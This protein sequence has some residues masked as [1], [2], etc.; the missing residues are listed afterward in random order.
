MKKKYIISP[1]KYLSSYNEGEKIYIGISVDEKDTE[2]LKKIGFS[3]PLEEGEHILPS[4]LLG[5]CFMENSEG[6]VTIHKD[7]E[8]E[9]AY[10]Y[11]EW[12][13]TD[14]HGNWHTASAY[15]P[16][17][18]YPRSKSSP[19]NIEFAIYKD[20]NGDNLIVTSSPIE[21]KE[22]NAIYFKTAINMMLALFGRFETFNSNLNKPVSIIRRLPWELLRPGT[23]GMSAEKLYSLLDSVKNTRKK[24]YK[25]DIDFLM[26]FNPSMAAIGDKGFQGYVV[27][28]YSNK[29]IAIV[30]S[31]IPD[32]A[33]Y[34]FEDDWERFSK[35]TK[36]EVLN[37][38]L[39]KDRIFHNDSWKSRI[40]EYLD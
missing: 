10:S 12:D 33:T 6:I 17:K 15:I 36:T 22:S 34:V 13:F 1:F 27:F 37:A 14:W 40:K 21:K 29:N 19:L 26:S 9:T 7:M 16:Y 24:M 2:I 35:L 38:N 20:R 18:R 31:I 23:K 28:F 11:R 39:Q 8:K 30:E 4:P 3:I 32:N 5:K 25:G